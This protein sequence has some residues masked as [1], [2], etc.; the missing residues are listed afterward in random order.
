MDIIFEVIDKDDKKI[1]LTNERWKH[2]KKHPHM[3]ESMLDEIKQIVREK[4]IQKYPTIDEKL[5]E[6]KIGETKNIKD[7]LLERKDSNIWVLNPWV[8]N[9][10]GYPLKEI[11]SKLIL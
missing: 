8:K 10:R 11:I 1:R 2:I 9:Q 6:M 4:S 3:D 7:I 5:T